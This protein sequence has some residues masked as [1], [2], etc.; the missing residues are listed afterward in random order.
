MVADWDVVFAAGAEHLVAI[1][2]NGSWHRQDIDYDLARRALAA[3]CLF[4]LDSDAHAHSELWFAEVAMAHATRAG[5]PADRIVNT[6]SEERLLA[7]SRRR[8]AAPPPRAT[9]AGVPAVRRRAPAAARTV[10][11]A[12]RRPRRSDPRA[13]APGQV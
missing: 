13:F 1:E 9:R 11:R 7:W 4:A 5:I 12:P 6:W 3:G 8:H 2:L 10:R